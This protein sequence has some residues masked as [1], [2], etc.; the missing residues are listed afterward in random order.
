MAS[1]FDGRRG[2]CV[3]LVHSRAE[4]NSGGE[5]GLG[6][7][8]RRSAGAVGDVQLLREARCGHAELVGRVQEPAELTWFLSVLPRSMRRRD[9]VVDAEVAGRVRRREAPLE[10]DPALGEVSP[11]GGCGKLCY[12][13]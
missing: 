10:R 13:G 3:D 4:H 5:P 1:C 2:I 8:E 11:R 7:C 9:H 12:G 6:W